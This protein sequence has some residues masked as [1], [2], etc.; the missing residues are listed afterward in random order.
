MK[1]LI[2]ISCWI[3]LI[4]SMRMNNSEGIQATIAYVLISILRELITLN[5]KNK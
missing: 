1:Y 2:Y 3:L 5:D 4:S